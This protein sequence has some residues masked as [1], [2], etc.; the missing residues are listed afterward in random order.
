VR[1]AFPRT[2]KQ[3]ICRGTLF[4]GEMNCPKLATF[5]QLSQISRARARPDAFGYAWAC[6]Q[7]ACARVL[8]LQPGRAQQAGYGCLGRHCE[9]TNQVDVSATR[10]RLRKTCWLVER[11]WYAVSDDRVTLQPWN[12]LDTV[13]VCLGC[14]GGQVGLQCRILS[15]RGCLS[16]TECLGWGHNQA[17][18]P[19]VG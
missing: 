7:K 5:E 4:R 13:R 2:E 11:L 12:W 10:K 16:R 14:K 15:P 6:D 17:R 9:H 3:R 18:S 19:S 8:P 1:T